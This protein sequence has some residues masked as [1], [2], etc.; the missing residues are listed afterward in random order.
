M[1]QVRSYDIHNNIY[2]ILGTIHGTGNQAALV[3]PGLRYREKQIY[4]EQARYFLG[5][6]YHGTIPSRCL[7]WHECFPLFVGNTAALP[8]HVK[9]QMEGILMFIKCDY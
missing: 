5:R 4:A 6:S 3:F 2:N 7:R 1:I 9:F 8:A